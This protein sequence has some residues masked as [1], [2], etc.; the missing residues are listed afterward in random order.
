M[1]DIRK[2]LDAARE[3][4]IQSREFWVDEASNTANYIGDALLKIDAA[5]AA[6]EAEPPQSPDNLISAYAVAVRADDPDTMYAAYVALRRALVAPSA[7][8][9]AWNIVTPNGN[10]IYQGTDPHI[11][12]TEEWLAK[13]KLVAPL[14][15]APTAQ[16]EPLTDAEIIDIWARSSFGAGTE[17]TAAA[18][19]ARAVERRV[20]GETR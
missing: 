19:F 12:Y 15:A 11:D 17:F 18:A 6:P 10:V 3:A 4:L 20:R 2:A 16:P 9:V 13:C 14:Y 1:T 7:E 8:P 5:L